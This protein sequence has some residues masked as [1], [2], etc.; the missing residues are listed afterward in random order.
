MLAF[1]HLHPSI[2]KIVEKT[3]IDDGYLNGSLDYY[4]IAIHSSKSYTRF[5]EPRKR[6][7]SFLFE[8]DLSLEK[9]KSQFFLGSTFPSS[10]DTSTDYDRDKRVIKRGMVLFRGYLASSPDGHFVMSDPEAVFHPS[11]LP[12]DL[13]IVD[14]SSRERKIMYCFGVLKNNGLRKEALSRLS[15]DQNE[16]NALINKGCLKMTSKGPIMT[17]IGEVNKL[18]QLIEDQW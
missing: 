4:T 10:S 2:K 9:T 17:S 16:I 11:Q 15:V 18:S 7:Q 14:L 3:F 5:M 12:K 6:M 1:K 8:I 13:P